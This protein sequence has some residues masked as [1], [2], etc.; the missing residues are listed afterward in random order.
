MMCFIRER[1]RRCRR[2][3]RRDEL[4]EIQ[5]LLKTESI[6]R[7]SAPIRAPK[8]FTGACPTGKNSGKISL[9]NV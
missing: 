7:D 4:I 2:R 8:L 1:C 6:C 5:C 3:R 9:P